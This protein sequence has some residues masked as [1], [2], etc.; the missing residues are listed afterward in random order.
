MQLN[1][2]HPLLQYCDLLHLTNSMEMSPSWEATSH[3]ATQE[4]PNILWNLRVHYHVHKSPPLV[5]M[6]RQ[7][8]SVQTTP[9]YFSNIHFNIIHPPTSWSSWWSLSFWLSHQ[10][11]ICIP[12]L[13]HSCYLHCPPY[14]CWLH[15]FN[16]TWQRVQV[17]KL[18]I[19]QFCPTSYHFIRLWSKYSPQHPVLRH[20]Q[21]MFLP[22]MSET[23]FYTHTEPQAK[24]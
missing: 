1:I 4:F 9:S 3:A 12:L 7:I 22:L 24:L 8:K 16:Y 13:P 19:M 23:M 5:L 18:L 11:S 6:L 17:M 2:Y 20:P 21:S 14:P 15:H 10:Y